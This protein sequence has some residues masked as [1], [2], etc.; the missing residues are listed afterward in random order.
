MTSIEGHLVNGLGRSADFTQMDWVRRQLIELAG[1]DPY[2]G[3]LNIALTDED[4]CRRWHGW[5]ELPAHIVEPV[6]AGFCR[7][8]CYPVIISGRIPGAVLLP[9]IRG[10]PDDKVELV[11]ALSIRKHL[12]LTENA[13]IRVALCRPLAVRAVLFDIDGTLVD[14][15]GAY[16]EVARDAASAFGVKVTAKHVHRSLA[17]GSNFW[18]GIIPPGRRDEDAVVKEMSLH[19]AREWPRVLREFGKVFSGLAQTLDVL[20]ASGIRLGIVSGA[21]PE[22]LDLLRAAGLLG[23]FEAIVL[24]SDVAKGKPDPEGLLKCLHKLNISPAEAVYV[25]DAPIDIQASRAAGVRA[26]GVLTG[27]GD[28][29][30]LSMHCPDRII[31]S[32][33]KLPDMVVPF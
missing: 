12:A 11:A 1:I 17:M 9:D 5:R 6:A 23:H 22:V 7:A 16:F 28:S 30:M 13:R 8:R 31:S 3:T 27:V 21:R 4:N 25:G 15:I 26:V 19:A 33:L 29:A 32:H 20:R 24:G 10:Y 18:K 2:P 14:S